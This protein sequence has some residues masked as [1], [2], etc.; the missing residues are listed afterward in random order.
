MKTAIRR[1]VASVSVCRWIAW[2]PGQ[3]HAGEAKK[4]ER[5]EGKIKQSGTMSGRFGKFLLSAHSLGSARA[6]LHF[7]ANGAAHWL[8]TLALLK[9]ERH[10]SLKR[11]I[12]A[13][14]RPG[15]RP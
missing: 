11:R 9:V 14:S 8:N 10:Y 3:R 5:R 6:A 13:R 12:F 2:I 7:R 4:A 1:D 15:R